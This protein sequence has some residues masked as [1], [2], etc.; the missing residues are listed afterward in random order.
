MPVLVRFTHTDSPMTAGREDDAWDASNV[1]H[2]ALFAHP[3]CT[4]NPR[5]S[6][7]R[8]IDLY[9]LGPSLPNRDHEE[10][11]PY[12]THLEPLLDH[13]QALRVTDRPL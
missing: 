1:A 12:A 10:Q 11:P 9:Q 13:L 5:L 4:R 7:Q 6:S 2:I 8:D 3:S